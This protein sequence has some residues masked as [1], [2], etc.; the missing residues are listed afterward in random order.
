MQN[1]KGHSAAV[2]WFSI[3]F[4]KPLLEDRVVREEKEAEQ[5]RRAS[6]SHRAC[7]EGQEGHVDGSRIVSQNQA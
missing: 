6:F 3:F 2:L 5:S 4:I 1:L 7:M